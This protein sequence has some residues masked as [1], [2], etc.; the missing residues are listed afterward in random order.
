MN[1]AETRAEHID[2]AL[3]AAGWGVVQGS[4]IRREYRI[5]LG[6]LQGHGRRAIPLCADYVLVYR[7]T[8]LA[9]VEAKAWDEPL[10]AGVAQ[11][12]DYAGKLSVR[13]TYSANGQGIYAIDMHEGTEGDTERFPSPD[14]LWKWTFEQGNAWRDR[15]SVVPFEDRGGYFQG[16]YYQDIAVERVLEA[17]AAGRNRVLLTLAT[18]TGKTFIAFQIAWKL[19]KSRWSL[20]GKADRQPKILFLADR[21]ILA[22]QAFLAFS[23][24][25]EDALIRIKPEEVQKKGCVP[26][27]GSV[28][29]TIFQTFMSG[30]E[31]DG[32]ASPYARSAWR[33]SC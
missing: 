10:T 28:F 30:P 29:F 3:A 18:G 12:K 5:T 26:T 15:F 9:V 14:E 20:S 8:K 4:R 19:F 33:L 7:N 16:R 24:F 25:P 17:I 11:A 32:K 22:D 1:E 31:K 21:N 6:R 23:S 2:P 13:F 27:N